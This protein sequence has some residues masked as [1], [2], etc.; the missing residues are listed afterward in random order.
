MYIASTQWNSGELLQQQW[1]PNLIE[2][3]N[4]LRAANILVF[5]SIYENGSWD[6]TKSILRQLRQTLEGIG[7][8]NQIN[9]EDVSQERIIAENKSTSGWLKTA[10]GNELRHIPYLASV[11]NKA[12]EP[13][14]SLAKSG[15]KFDKLLYINDVVYSVGL[16]SRS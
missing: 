14:S 1:I 13:L 11:R 10:Y 6:S 12:S 15:V 4:D 8:Q 2:V 5:V 3:I 7:V 16:N 9:T